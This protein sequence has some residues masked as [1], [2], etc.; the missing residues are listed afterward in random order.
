M[1]LFF[2]SFATLTTILCIASGCVGITP[3]EMTARRQTTEYAFERMIN[4]AKAHVSDVDD[5][6]S[7]ASTVALALANM[8][9]TE[10][11]AF[12]EA[13]GQQSGTLNESGMMQYHRSMRATNERI[14]P[15][16]AVVMWYRHNKLEK[17][18]DS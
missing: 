10:Y 7:D 8:C 12:V 4:K 17:H 11:E 1:R 3:Q 14:R 18:S 15:F 13:F 6:S 9:D 5:E 16:L 2:Q